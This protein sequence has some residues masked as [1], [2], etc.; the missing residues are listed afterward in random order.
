MRL[1]IEV[2]MDASYQDLDLSKFGILEDK[3]RILDV[4]TRGEMEE[5]IRCKDVLKHTLK[6]IQNKYRKVRNSKHMSEIR[7][8]INGGLTTCYEKMNM[9]EKCIMEKFHYAREH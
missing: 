1:D 3:C 8:V 4:Y 5:I 2:E 7:W 9:V 6:R